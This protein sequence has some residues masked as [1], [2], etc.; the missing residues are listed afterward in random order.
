VPGPQEIKLLSIYRDIVEEA[1]DLISVHSL[2]MEALFMYGNM[3]YSRVLYAQP[4]SLLGKSLLCILHDDDAE[5]LA[6]VLKEALLGNPYQVGRRAVSGAWRGGTRRAHHCCALLAGLLVPRSAH[7]QE[8]AGRAL[9]R[10]GF[11]RSPPLHHESHAHVRSGADQ[12]V[13]PPQW[14][15]CVAILQPLEH[16]AAKLYSL[17]P[18]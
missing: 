5:T 9:L 7:G 15:L 18:G 8:V 2:S 14:F 4:Q 17:C 11:A 16:R 13:R 1:R 10:N 3:A 12:R 6:K